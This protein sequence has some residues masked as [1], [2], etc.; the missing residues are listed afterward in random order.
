MLDSLRFWLGFAVVIGTV[1]FVGWE[2]PLSYRFMSPKDIETLENPPA[3]VVAATPVP[4]PATPWMFSADRK[5]AL[6]RAPYNPNGYMT[7]RS[8]VRMVPTPVSSYPYSR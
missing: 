4:K 1:L 5:T 8:G 3:R 2:Q 6:D 7:G